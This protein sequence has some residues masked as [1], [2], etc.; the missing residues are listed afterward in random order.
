MK[1]FQVRC[2]VS[3]EVKPSEDPSTIERTLR[4]LAY[5]D[6]DSKT[7][8]SD[9]RVHL[10]FSGVAALKKIRDQA[11]ARRVR[12][13]LRRL[14]VSNY[15]EGKVT[16]MLNRQA[17]TKGIIAY[18]ESESESPLGPVYLEIFTDNLQAL[19]AYLTGEKSFQR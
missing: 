14:L 7:K 13:V 15:A 3:A 9:N 5:P 19:I 18:I 17:L 12:A 11:A 16:L 6:V 4:L 8:I 2:E 1:D 10:T